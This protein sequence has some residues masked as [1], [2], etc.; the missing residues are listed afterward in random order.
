MKIFMEI[1]TRFFYKMTQYVSLH[2]IAFS[3]FHVTFPTCQLTLA[4]NMK[5]S[6]NDFFST[7]NQI[8]N[9]KLH[10]PVQFQF[11]LG[12]NLKVVL[13]SHLCSIFENL[14]YGVKVFLTSLK[15]AFRGG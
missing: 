3:A 2:P 15:I 12:L 11:L 1:R 14:P 6:T 9:G 5:F 7:C 10:F 4:Q 8:L 13:K